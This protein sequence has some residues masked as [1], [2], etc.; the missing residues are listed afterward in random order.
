MIL[1][2]V[3]LF[4]DDRDRAT[5]E[6]RLIFLGVFFLQ[7]RLKGLKYV[8]MG[9]WFPPPLLFPLAEYEIINTSTSFSGFV[10]VRCRLYDPDR[11]SVLMSKPPR[12]HSRTS[13]WR[14]DASLRS[15]SLSSSRFRNF[16]NAS[17]VLSKTP[18]SSTW[19]RR[20]HGR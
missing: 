1:R 17:A 18:T 3:A 6:F 7:T 8:S 20:S 2:I 5:A 12:I 10:F 11:K 14:F 4:E 13:V 15:V 9:V 19:P 16:S